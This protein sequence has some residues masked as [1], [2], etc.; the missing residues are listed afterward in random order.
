M[1]KYSVNSVFLAVALCFAALLPAGALAAKEVQSP[2]TELTMEELF[3]TP[4][5]DPH[6]LAM[7]AYVW[8]MPMVEWAKVRSYQT[9][10]DNPWV[11]RPAHNVGAPINHFGRARVL[12]GP[13]SKDGVGVNNDTLYTNVWFDLEA[14]PF[15][16][17][18]PDF[19]GRYYTFT[20][21][22][23]D[24]SSAESLG[25]RTHGSQMPPL[26]VY[27]ENFTGEVPEGLVP[28]RGNTR[29]ILLSGRI[30]VD[31][32]EEDLARAHA[33]QDQVRSRTFH[34][35]QAGVE[36]EP[37]VTWQR[38][39]LPSSVDSEDELAFFHMLGSV[40]Q[41]WLIQP[42]EAELVASLAAIG[43]T[44]ETGFDPAQLSPADLDTLRRGLADARVL[45]DYHSHRLGVDS[46][47]WTT[48]Y[49]GGFFGNDY[50]LRAAVAK[51]QIGVSV[52]EEAVYPIGRVDSTGEPLTGEHQY[53][54]RLAGDNLPPVKGFWSVT[55]Y[56]D[57]G[58]LVDNPINRYAIGDRTIGLVTA[59]NGDIVIALQ[60]EE[61]TEAGVNWLPTP[62][63]PFYLMMRLYIAE[64]AVLDGTWTPPPIERINSN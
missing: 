35:W 54:I 27:G 63:G 42:E 20:V 62:E 52:P 6:T 60:R 57:D 23:G 17:E 55:L 11:E 15:V 25:H 61:P 48:N 21:Y 49:S 41:D 58:I 50:L 39:L 13:D 30:L 8:G 51:D 18:T 22:Q 47:G 46:G 5:S 31:G 1:K 59:E 24:T 16:V 2:V 32:S 37:P 9:R 3:G 7:R 28:V 43:L 29:Y 14:G 36:K 56:D 45:V 33:L 12:Y 4:S 53:R 34:A 19:K 26:F 10:P 64:E 44:P 40:L 38:A